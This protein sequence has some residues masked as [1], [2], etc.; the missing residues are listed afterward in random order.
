MTFANKGFASPALI[1]IL[2]VALAVGAGIL[3]LRKNHSSLPEQPEQTLST[4]TEEQR[5]MK[6]YGKASSDEPPLKLKSIGVNFDDFKFTKQKFQ[7]D[8]I[9]MGFGF[10]IPA[11]M[12]STGSSK[13]NPQPTFVVPLGTPVRAIVDGTVAAMPTLW[14]GDYSV[15]ITTN[16]QLQ[17][18]AYEIEHLIN[19]K[20][21]VGDK[22]TAG[23]IVGE[24][25][26]FNSGAPEGFGAVE[27]GLLRGGQVPEHLCPFAY[28]DASIREET[29]AKIR[30]FFQSWEDYVG[31]QTLYND[32]AIPGCLSLD[33]IEG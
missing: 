1:L 20:V 17:K 6:D 3:I 2:V 33:P 13:A 32:T 4:P 18:W 7:F 22:V 8:R 12:S 19:P 9:F 11:N 24:V 21:K 29:F 30:D 28:L 27:I 26:N 5:A 25:S 16:G 10:V 15:Q 31:D 23:Q 14:S